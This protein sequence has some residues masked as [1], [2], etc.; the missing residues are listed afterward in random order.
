MQNKEETPFLTLVQKLHQALN[1]LEKFPVVLHHELAGNVS[2]LKFLTQPFK[3]KLVKES[4]ESNLKE[5]GDG[6]I[7]IEPMASVQAISDYLATRVK[8][9]NSLKDST[10]KLT[11]STDSV[12]TMEIEEPQVELQNKDEK[13]VTAIFLNFNF[14]SVNF[15]MMTMKKK[16]RKTM[17]KKRNNKKKKKKRKTKKKRMRLNQNLNRSLYMK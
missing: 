11:K 6:V 4:T 13:E 17:K 5:F 10:S 3:L 16:K 7:L 15:L 14:I 1:K 9:D 2:G 12:D 8:L